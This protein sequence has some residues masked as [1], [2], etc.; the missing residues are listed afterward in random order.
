MGKGRFFSITLSV[1]QS[2]LWI[3][4]NGGSEE[5]N[6]GF[7]SELQSWTQRELE[8]IREGLRR[9]T[10]DHPAFLTTLESLPEDPSAPPLVQTLL[11]SSQSVHVGPMAAVAGAVAEALGTKLVEKYHFRELVIEN[12]G[13][14]WISIRSPLRVAVYAGLSSLSGKIGITV[15]PEH[16]PCGLACSS[17]TVGPSKSFGKADAAV[18]VCKSAPLADA[19]AT[20]LGNRIRY[21]GDLLPAVN[22]L[23]DMGRQETLGEDKNIMGI[24]AILADRMAAVGTL[25]IGGL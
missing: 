22:D 20:A 12:G 19:W 21:Q 16:S 6:P 14:L 2:D 25:P 10:T 23:W 24:L 8:K 15:M 17:G 11:R 18:V 1:E 9:Y 7:V 13:D 4:W 3:G 5:G